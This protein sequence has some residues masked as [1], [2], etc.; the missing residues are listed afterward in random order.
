MRPNHRGS[1]NAWES[2]CWILKSF[3]SCSLTPF[4]CL[5]I[6]TGLSRARKVV[7]DCRHVFVLV[8][9][10]A[11]LGESP[12]SQVARELL[13]P[14]SVAAF[15]IGFPRALLVCEVVRVSTTA[16]DETLLVSLSPVPCLW[17]KAVRAAPAVL[18]SVPPVEEPEEVY[19]IAR[20]FLIHGDLTDQTCDRSSTLAPSET[21]SGKTGV[22]APLAIPLWQKS[23]SR[24]VPCW[25]SP[26]SANVASRASHV[27]YHSK[28]TGGLKRCGWS[29]N[30][31]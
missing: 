14:T 3:S 6:A 15:T 5:Q 18:T 17:S 26:M 1:G 4:D 7:F 31:V 11:Y 16:P 10:C 25:N 13:S 30:S 22:T 20:A 8:A 9:C 21:P 12:A 19:L 23:T 24:I 29:E 2:S 28:T 27:G